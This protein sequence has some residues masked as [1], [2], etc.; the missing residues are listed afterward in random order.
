MMIKPQC[1]YLWKDMHLAQCPYAPIAHPVKMPLPLSGDCIS[2]CQ[3]PVTDAFDQSYSITFQ[4]IEI[5]GGLA[6]IT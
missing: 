4:I 2:F 5:D 1:G 6:K 3:G